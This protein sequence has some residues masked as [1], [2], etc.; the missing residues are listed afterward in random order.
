MPGKGSYGPGGVWIYR[1]AHRI[2]EESPETPKHVAYAVATQQ[3][4]K[5]G[6]SP[7]GFRTER[8]MREA[9]AKY[10]L[11]KQE[12]QKMAQFGESPLGEVAPAIGGLVAGVPMGK[13]VAGHTAAGLAPYGRK[14]RSEDIARRLAL[15]GAPIGGIAA[16]ALAKKYGLGGRAA[17]YVQRAAPR[18]LIA[19]PE[20]ER[21]ALRMVFPAVMGIGGGAAGGLLTGLGVGGI[22]ALRG[23]PYKSV[24][25]KTS[26]VRLE[27]FFDEL[28]KIGTLYASPGEVEKGAGLDVPEEDKSQARKLFN[29]SRKVATF[30]AKKPPEPNIRAV[31]TEV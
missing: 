10:L 26:S 30:G 6:K 5:V 8:G 27:A 17:D 4:H 12:Y 2:L 25:E 19:S 7:K 14:T 29:K 16:L 1:R 23:S 21:E 18:G 15:I 22:Q 13:A 20:A 31:A 3:G 24:R 9:K 28:Q 11:P